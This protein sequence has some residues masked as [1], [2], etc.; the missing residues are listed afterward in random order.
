MT[1]L[2]VA[3]APRQNF[4]GL[5]G[6]G[7]WSLRVQAPF[8]K[9]TVG[10]NSPGLKLKDILSQTQVLQREWRPP[11]RLRLSKKYAIEMRSSNRS[12]RSH[13]EKDPF[14]A[15]KDLM[16]RSLKSEFYG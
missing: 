3:M 4:S 15:A 1:R 9:L 7:T 11:H 13:E 5:S 16:D 14:L 2:G 6:I 10:I 12:T 8:E